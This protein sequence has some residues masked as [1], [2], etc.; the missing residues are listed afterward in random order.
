MALVTKEWGALV[1]LFEKI[2]Q[3]DVRQLAGR[4]KMLQMGMPVP[5][6][7]MC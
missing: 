3:I 6:Y 4:F 7:A 1:L 5:Y 2:L